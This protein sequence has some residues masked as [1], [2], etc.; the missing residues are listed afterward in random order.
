MANYLQTNDLIS[1]L[2][3]PLHSIDLPPTHK[4]PPPYSE[5]HP[6]GPSA[7]PPPQVVTFKQVRAPERGKSLSH[8]HT[9]A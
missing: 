5:R 7:P 8:E 1:F 4:P 2:F 3:M 9:A 6:S